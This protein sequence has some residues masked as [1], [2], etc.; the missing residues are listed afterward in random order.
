MHARERGGPDNLIYF[1]ADLLFAQKH[2]T[3]LTYGA[4]SYSNADVIKAL[5]T[6]IVFS[7]W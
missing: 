5:N 6:G 7:R 1:I 4:K 3:G 2:A